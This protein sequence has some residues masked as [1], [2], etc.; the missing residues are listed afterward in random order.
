MTLAGTTGSALAS[1]GVAL[2]PRM[3]RPLSVTMEL[4]AVEIHIPQIARAVTFR[5]IIEVGR[6][7]IAA[8]SAGGHG[9]G[10][11][12]LAELDDGDKAVAAGPVNL[13]RPL[14]QARA[15]RGQPA[16][17]RPSQAHR[18]AGPALGARMTH[19]AG[20]TL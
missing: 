17:H 4:R 3:I 5:L 7:R 6:R 9:F 2:V 19:A 11:H 18:D 12:S 20:E 15:E 14:V 16:P 1:R 13:L 10:S 8:L